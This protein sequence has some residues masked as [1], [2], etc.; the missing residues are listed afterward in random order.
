MNLSNQ[1]PGN[2]PSSPVIFSVHVEA[3]AHIMKLWGGHWALCSAKCSFVHRVAP[4][5]WASPLVGIMFG[6]FFAQDPGCNAITPIL[7]TFLF[8]SHFF[9]FLIIIYFSKNHHFLESLSHSLVGQNI[10]KAFFINV[11]IMGK[12]WANIIVL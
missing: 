6:N 7:V 3:S 9:S 4:H 11:T 12:I 10:C 1:W 8:V 2:C 5:G